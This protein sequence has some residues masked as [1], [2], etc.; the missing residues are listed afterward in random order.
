M[1]EDERYKK[2]K[3][4]EDGD[5]IFGDAA[6]F[7]VTRSGDILEETSTPDEC[8]M[9]VKWNHP[10]SKKWNVGDITVDYGENYFQYLGNRGLEEIIQGVEEALKGP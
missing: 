7:Q 5:L 10:E 8:V 9:V 4:C 2:F 1:P 3:D 6:I